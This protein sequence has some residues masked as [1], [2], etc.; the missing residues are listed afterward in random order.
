[1]AGLHRFRERKVR[2]TLCPALARW[3]LSFL[4]PRQQRCWPSLTARGF[5][6][7]LTCLVGVTVVPL[8]SWPRVSVGGGVWLGGTEK[9]RLSVCKYFSRA[10]GCFGVARSRFMQSVQW[11]MRGICAALPRKTEK[12]AGKHKMKQGIPTHDYHKSTCIESHEVRSHVVC[13]PSFASKSKICCPRDPKQA[14]WYPDFSARKATLNEHVPP[15]S[16]PIYH[17]EADK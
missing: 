15:Q 4:W 2:Q 11:E 17:P 16:C 6:W 12:I 1:M 10:G 3:V 9:W 13:S 8:W 7:E 5:G 14:V